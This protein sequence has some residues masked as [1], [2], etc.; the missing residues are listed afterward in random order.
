MG[1][2]K[3]MRRIT[4]KLETLRGGL[5][6]LLRSEAGIA[7][8]TALTTTAL[9]LGLG[10]VAAV[11][12]ISAQS[13]STRDMDT[14]LALAAADAGAER[15]IYRYNRVETTP[16]S[17]CLTATA[18]EFSSVA[19]DGWCPAINGSVD[20]ATY[21]YRVMP[22]FDS[23]GEADEI[24]VVSTG[25]SD[26][27]SR[28]INLTAE[29]TVNNPFSEFQVIGD[30]SVDLDS[31]SSI[32][33]NVATNGDMTLNSNTEICGMIQVPP[34]SAV[35]FNGNSGQCSGYG[36]MNGSVDLPLVN[37]GNVTTVNSNGRFFTQNIRSSDR[38]TWDAATRTLA[39]GSNSSLT[40][41]GG[42]YSF[43]RLTMESNTTMYIAAGVA[44][45]RVYFDS[46][47]N[48]NQ[49]D[50]TVQMDLSSN[51]QITST[52]SDAVAAFLFVG[53]PNLSTAANLS[54]NTTLCNF[55]VVLYGPLTDFDLNSNTNVCGG[56]AGKTVHMDSNAHVG[57]HP[58]LENFELPMP[59]HFVPTRYVECGPSA[60]GAPNGG[61]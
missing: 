34:G 28:T 17:P 53:S 20:S 36:V 9:A 3:A 1:L 44:D 30:D 39:M 52:G 27:V 54:S 47:E 46:P 60:T 7:L 41:G 51:S 45:V 23:E 56:V 8:P 55:E 4:S 24:D 37:Q 42:N 50:G 38:V 49:P 6:T 40:L 18:G 59:A 13:G 33:A 5:F 35:D 57:Q 12:S 43:C 61:C 19:A 58:G 21:S 48:C 10:S 16:T 22:T 15:A 11:S 25:T 31:N 32:D 2:A 26:D 14:K 29:T